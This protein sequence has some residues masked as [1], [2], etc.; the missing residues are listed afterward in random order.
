MSTNPRF[1]K[2][3]KEF[4]A[5]IRIISQRVGYTERAKQ[6]RR[7]KG[8][9]PSVGK[10]TVGPIKI[11]TLAEIQAALTEMDLSASH[12]IE[13]GAR[14]TELGKRVL[15]YFEHRA[16]A[17]NNFV[18]PRLMDKDRARTAFER[19]C[20]K[21]RPSCPLPMNKQKGEKKT[22]AYFTGIINMHIEV[23][24]EGMPCDYDTRELTTFT[25]DLEP[26]RTLARRIDGAFPGPVNPVAV[27]EVKEYYYTTTFGSRVS[28]GVYETL[29]DGMEL[30]E[31]RD[32]HFAVRHYL[33]IDD[34][35]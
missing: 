9:T 22:P 7:A 20:A 34:H 13:E 21:L 18:E 16:D 33:M 29:L 2:L 26:F 11:P 32:H 4:W 14:P 23:N 15:G 10:K 5:N 27:W 30:K 35:F 19:L 28:D 8:R 24:A 6:E 3:V 12:L 17:L 1:V 25:R 31:L